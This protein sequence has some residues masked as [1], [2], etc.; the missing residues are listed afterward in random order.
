MREYFEEIRLPVI[1]AEGPLAPTSL[2]GAIGNSVGAAERVCAY[3]HAAKT[4]DLGEIQRYLQDGGLINVYHGGSGATALHL[5]AEAP[6]AEEMMLFF[7][8]RADCNFMELDAGGNPAF[9]RIAEPGLR[10]EVEAHTVAQ[11]LKHDID[12]EWAD[13][14]QGIDRS[15]LESVPGSFDNRERG[16]DP[17]AGLNY[18]YNDAASSNQVDLA[19]SL[20]AAG[21]PVN[22]LDVAYGMAT[23]HLVVAHRA[24]DVLKFL[25]TQPDCDFLM[26]SREG[27]LP[28]YY[29][30]DTEVFEIVSQRER[31]QAAER[32]L[33][34]P[35]CESGY[36]S[37]RGRPSMG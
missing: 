37:K 26:P 31:E 32:G 4:G 21:A 30:D 19:K 25:V 10:Y 20:L 15:L 8:S 16:V 33:P 18:A 17:A 13:A 6:N 34:E 36:L 11:Y 5:A 7:M 29:A 23:T 24:V 14:P 22:A 9:Q 2:T 28:S 1:D 12:P 3:V 27:E 35:K